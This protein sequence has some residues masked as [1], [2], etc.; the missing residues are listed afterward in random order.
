[1]RMNE[2]VPGELW[3]EEAYGVMHLGKGSFRL[4]FHDRSPQ[5]SPFYGS[6]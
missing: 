6:K 2:D 4:H 1:M 5:E 3:Y